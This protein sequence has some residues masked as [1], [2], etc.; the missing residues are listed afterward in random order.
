MGVP[1][2]LKRVGIGSSIVLVATTCLVAP[3][4]AAPGAAHFGVTT[5]PAAATLPNADITGSPPAWHPTALS[6]WSKKYT[7]CTGKKVTWTMTNQTS[8]T[9][10]I[11]SGGKPVG[12]LSPGYVYDVCSYGPAGSKIILKIG[13][14][15]STLT[16][17]LK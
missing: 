2:L 5:G 14:T 12:S 15:R 17:T 16:V 6:V 10:T 11:R 13:G 3:T 4:A 9:V 7:T 1:V 8:G